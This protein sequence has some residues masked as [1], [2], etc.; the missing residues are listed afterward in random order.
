VCMCVYVCVCVCVCAC[1][2][3]RVRAHACACGCGIVCTPACAGSACLLEGMCVD[4]LADA[5]GA[6]HLALLCPSCWGRLQRTK[7]V[8]S[9]TGWGSSRRGRSACSL[10]APICGT[11]TTLLE[12]ISPTAKAGENLP[13]HP[14]YPVVRAGAQLAPLHEHQLAREL[15][16]HGGQGGQRHLA[17]HAVHLEYHLRRVGGGRTLATHAG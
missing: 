11:A 6:W 14:N 2:R 1:V 3:I 15:G 13:Q 5:G 16:L 8:G 12:P 7:A 9:T 4:T 17:R 10:P